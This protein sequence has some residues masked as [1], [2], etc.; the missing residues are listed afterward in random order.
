M[1][2]AQLNP[3][4]SFFSPA[5]RG[6]STRRFWHPTAPR[7]T[8]SLVGAYKALPC[9]AAS[10]GCPG[11]GVL[12]QCPPQGFALAVSCKARLGT[13]RLHLQNTL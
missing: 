4:S 13:E 7:Y 8:H 3:S 5:F 12:G 6:N 11:M 2:G 9:K 10:Q 1:L